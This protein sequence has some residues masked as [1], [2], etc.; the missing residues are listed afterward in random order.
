MKFN[1]TSRNLAVSSALS[2][3]SFQAY[4]CGNSPYMAEVCP[5]LTPFCPNGYA[6]ANGQLL[7]ISQ[8]QALFSLIGTTYGGD[9]KTTFG[10]PDLRG[11]TVIGASAAALPANV[12]AVPM[13]AVVGSAE[14]VLNVN[15]MPVHTH[16]FAAAPGAINVQLQASSAVG[17]ATKPSAGSY[18]AAGTATDPQS[19]DVSPLQNWSSTLTSPVSLG[20]ISATGSVAGNIA[21]AGGSQPFS[22][23]T[24]AVAIT[25]CIS[26]TG[27][28][29]QN[30]GK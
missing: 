9:G 13:G 29:P 14:T 27:V 22:T 11:R 17:N 12:V 28:Y 25:Y 1:A 3:L 4:A 21:P 5:F 10:L 18:L 23:Q 6:T 16:A 26:I 8:N 24:P 20:G 7:P 30:S 2:L 15:Q 19:G